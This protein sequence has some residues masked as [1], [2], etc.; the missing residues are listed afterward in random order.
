MNPVDLLTRDKFREDVFLRDS[1]CCVVCGKS[2]KDAHHIIERRLWPDGGYYLANGATVCENCHI[3][4]EQTLISC[5]ELRTLCKIKEVLLPPH[6]YRDVTYD[7]WGNIIVSSDHRVRGEL[8]DDISVQKILTPVMHM[9]DITTVKYPRTYHLPWSP[10]VGRDDRI[11]PDLSKFEGRNIVVTVKMDGENTSLYQHGLHARSLNYEPHPSRN[12]IKVLHSTIA[13]EIPNGWRICGENLYA[14]HSI[15]YKELPTY[16]LVFSIWN[17]RNE[18][19][20]WHDTKEWVELL[21][22]SVVPVLY[23][24]PWDEKLIKS[25]YSATYKN[26]DMEGYVV[27]IEEGFPYRDFRSCVAKYVR[28]NHVQTH[29]NWMRQ[30]VV[31]NE[32]KS[33]STK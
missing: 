31:P 20:S 30:M 4:A 7:K 33:E 15:H 27:R 26:N 18:C 5:E 28:A 13:H 2:G 6:L 10:G 17:E 24:G 16:F 21:G 23:Q 25:L 8:F 22:L 11:I 9:F 12:L 14:K 3:K 29:G 1:Y 19:L 32:L